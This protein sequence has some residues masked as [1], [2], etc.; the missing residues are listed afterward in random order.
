MDVNSW[1]IPHIPAASLAHASGF[2]AEID[3]PISNRTHPIKP[4]ASEG[5]SSRMRPKDLGVGAFV[6]PLGR[7]DKLHGP[8]RLSV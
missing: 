1:H 6:I 4:D 7:R 5:I 8:E 2:F 3:V